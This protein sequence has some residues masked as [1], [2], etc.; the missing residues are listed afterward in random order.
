MHPGVM[1]AWTLCD[2]D[3]MT[4]APYPSDNLDEVTCPKCAKARWTA[5][6]ANGLE[7]A[8]VPDYKPKN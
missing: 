5:R 8:W 7:P 3:V 6:L 1:L 2:Q 4:G